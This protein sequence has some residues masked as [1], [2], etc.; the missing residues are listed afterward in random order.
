MATFTRRA[1]LIVVAVLATACAETAEPPEITRA[2][3]PPAPATAT[4]TT[5]APINPTEADLLAQADLRKVLRAAHEARDES[6]SFE[7]TQADI[8]RR[9]P[10]VD[11]IS[12]QEA[13]LKPGVAFDGSNQRATLYARSESGTW[14]C[15]GAS[16]SGDDYGFGDS[17][18]GALSACTDG[19][20]A[21]GWGNPFSASGPDEAAVAATL[22]SLAEALA[23][24]DGVAAADTF[25]PDAAC[26]SEELASQWPEG[27]VLTDSNELALTSLA[28]AGER[29]TVSARLGSLEQSEWEL[30]GGQGVWRVVGNPCLAFEAL[31]D[32]RMTAAANELLETA[33]F[34][35]RSVFVD[36]D[37]FGFGDEELANRDGGLI[38]VSRQEVGFGTLYYRGSTSSGLL[39]T[40]GPSGTFYCAVESLSAATV[41]GTG[42]RASD[43]WTVGGCRS[44]SAG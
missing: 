15:V 18:E 16:P 43:V 29:A 38:F 35:V 17:F 44:H 22:Q 7:N 8:D 23:T 26:R 32:D 11:V 25:Q 31:I 39:V 34:T 28:I 21:G 40:G 30:V 3:L 36:K 37:G 14:F 27:L 2:L 12:L 20:T 24:G 10:T 42:T 1:A 9:V 6:G 33:L 41:Y 13:A 19:A 5:T 4:T